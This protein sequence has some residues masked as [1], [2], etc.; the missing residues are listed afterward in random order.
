VRP[1]FNYHYSREE[2]EEWVPKEKNVS[3]G[4]EKVYGYFNSHYHG[5]AAE[6]CIGIL[7]MLNGGNPEQTRVKDKIIQYNLKKRPLVYERRL[8]EYL[9]PLSELGVEDLLLKM[10]DR[11]RFDRAKKIRDEE[12]TI[13]KSTERRIEAKIRDYFIQIDLEKKT[14]T[15][16]CDDWR[17]GLRI[18][19]ICKHI[20]KLFLQLPS[21]TSTPLLEDMIKEKDK[22]RFRVPLS[23]T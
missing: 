1:W 18:R 21:E 20:G 16:D 5:Y 3:K 6:N 4:V 17:K 19:R 23:P 2:L 10:T 14:L 9:T 7:E 12:L 22:W 15:H 8:E 11:A 13:E